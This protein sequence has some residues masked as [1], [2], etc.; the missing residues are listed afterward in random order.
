MVPCTT[1]SYGFNLAI[2]L[3]EEMTERF[4]IPNSNVNNKKNIKKIIN[5]S[6]GSLVPMIKAFVIS[7][8]QGLLY[9]FVFGCHG[10]LNEA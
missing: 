7:G 4:L 5:N 3:I 9:G 1:P 2:I 10:E 6:I 8:H